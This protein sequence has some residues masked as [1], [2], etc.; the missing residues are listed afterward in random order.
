V[1]AARRCFA[2]LVGIVATASCTVA[3]LDYTG[4]R[5]PCPD[6]WTCEKNV[7]QRSGG[8]TPPGGDGATRVS[9]LRA[10]WAT[11]NSIRWEWD[12]EGERDDF[13]SIE[14]AIS[15]PRP[16]AGGAQKWTATERPELAH[17]YLAT[18]AGADMRVTST[19][20]EG[21]D[22]DT[23]YLATLTAF[24]SA[25]RTSVTNEARRTTEVALS[26]R[27]IV[28]SEQSPSGYRLPLALEV[29]SGCGATG[30]DRCIRYRPAS[31]P[32]AACPDLTCT[33]NLRW[34]NLGVTTTAVDAGVFAQRAYLEAY[35]RSTG[36][37]V[38]YNSTLWLFVVGSGP[39]GEC[40]GIDRLAC[41]FEFQPWTFQPRA[42]YRRLQVPL[43]FLRSDT[44]MM[45]THADLARGI[46]GFNVGGAWGKNDT[47]E[48]DEVAIWY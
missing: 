21:H 8:A 23:L 34:Q 42:E 43:R 30:T 13:G 33:Q 46:Y 9:N 48:I 37:I 17:P 44:A 18:R 31:D 2:I 26:R 10:S 1:T 25:G 4:K 28:F 3:E 45:L 40:G 7:C 5:C 32:E 38:S 6:A 22:P 41:Q 36:T 27:V 15:S 12:V 14:I 39:N 29:A 47:V 11:P 19:V 35:V 20:T 16:G 24:D